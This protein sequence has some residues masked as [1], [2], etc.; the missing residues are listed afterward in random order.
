MTQ[1][2]RSIP[3]ASRVEGAGIWPLDMALVMLGGLVSI[4]VA[5]LLRFDDPRPLHNAWTYLLGIPTAFIATSMLARV[6][7]SERME[8][9]I[10]IGFLIS[11]ALHLVLTFVAINT[12]LFTGAWPEAFE[13]VELIARSQSQAAQFVEIPSSPSESRPDYLRPVDAELT[14]PANPS[15][16]PGA[17][18]DAPFDPSMSE[19]PSSLAPGSYSIER[20]RAIPTLDEP[21]VITEVKIPDRSSVPQ[22]AGP[23]GR[24][25]ELPELARG[26]SPNLGNMTPENRVDVLRVGESREAELATSKADEVQPIVAPRPKLEATS[27]SESNVTAT[28]EKTFE[29][30]TAVESS[31]PSRPGV[32][33]NRGQSSPT[34]IDVPQASATTSPNPDS[35]PI[36][37]TLAQR[38]DRE[39]VRQ[40]TPGEAPPSGQ[41]MP[42]LSSIPASDV[43]ARIGPSSIA[44]TIVP[45]QQ[46]GDRR[47]S[48]DSAAGGLESDPK[49][50]DA[51]IPPRRTTRSSVS[52]GVSGRVVAPSER[53]DSEL[54]PGSNEGTRQSL[55]MANNIGTRDSA[56]DAVT[57]DPTRES[58]RLGSQGQA[59]RR[60]VSSLADATRNTSSLAD[61]GSTKVGPR[62]GN[63]TTPMFGASKAPVGGGS[64]GVGAPEVS[65][66]E[67]QLDRFRR[68]NQG[69]IAK[70]NARVPIPSPAFK[71]RMRR[72][73]EASSEDLKAMGPL[74]PQTED[75]IERGLEF[76]SK[77]Q[78]IDG[79]WRLEDFDSKPLIRSNS[80]ATALALLAFQG[81]GYSHEQYKYQSNCKKALEWLRSVQ[82]KNGDL[83][84]AQD[85][86]SDKNG[87]LYSHAIATLALCEA[88][89]MTRDEELREPAQR[90]IDFLVYSQDPLA[91][92]WRYTPRVGSDTSVTGWGMMALKS[93][94]LSGLNVPKET[95]AGISRWLNSS[96][97]S[98]RERYLY[99]YNWQA[100]TPQ[101]QHGRIPTPVM[102]SVGLLMRLYLG[103]RRSNPDMVRGADWLLERKPSLGTKENPKRDTYYWYYSTQVLFHMGADRW[104]AWYSTLYPILIESQVSEG[105]YAGS[106]DPQGEIP[107]AWGEYAG[108]LYVTTMNLLS[109]EV[110]Y[111]H[112]PIYDATG[113]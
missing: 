82:K 19:L 79:S 74:G 97:A 43:D 60:D 87:W 38:A 58:G 73:E 80:A 21:S 3:N 22:P 112:L 1:R 98:A 51:S 2:T 63:K 59:T 40:S 16:A 24:Q 76:L 71:Q 106:W 93:A 17:S 90:A 29:Q 15:I 11:T 50:A 95:Y 47:S 7:V 49:F 37:S 94:E 65:S 64:K 77:Y 27:T 83:Y 5:R 57:L 52:G 67:L 108:R 69:T 103:W 9:S 86:A 55:A 78:R 75:A 81:A 62:L 33:P 8:K 66:A 84:Q 28:L 23:K 44:Q 72:N 34:R 113:Q 48:S 54:A 26:Q 109:L 18:S 92:G 30:N 101:T 99:R 42:S 85:E 61:L 100:N 102:T 46:R 110:T 20:Q 13:K 36:P 4:L 35:V 68:S 45:L 88:Y 104:R 31:L 111:R 89:G 41:A 91:G 14:Q 105:R 70:Q 107:D 39:M 56:S 12:V 10:Q 32:D 53:L 96:E 25:I 6:L